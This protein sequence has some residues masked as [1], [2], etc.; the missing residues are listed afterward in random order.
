[1]NERK[2]ETGGLS[3]A[4]A[5]SSGSLDRTFRV[6]LESFKILNYELFA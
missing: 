4:Q 6:I 3:G 1:M 5:G 2:D